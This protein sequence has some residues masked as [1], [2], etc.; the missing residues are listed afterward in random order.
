MA[1]H[2]HKWGSMVCCISCTDISDTYSKHLCF[3]PHLSERIINTE[4]H[5]AANLIRWSELENEKRREKKRGG[6]E[7]GRARHKKVT[8]REREPGHISPHVIYSPL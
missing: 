6:G 2:L 5:F 4:G 3:R 8:K 1:S 7:N